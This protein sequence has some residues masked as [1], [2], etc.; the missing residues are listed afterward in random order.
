MRSWSCRLFVVGTILAAYASAAPVSRIV[1]DGDFADWQ[2]V[3]VHTDPQD[4]QHDT[5]HTLPSDTPAYVDHEDVDL[6][7][8]KVTHDE[9]NVYAYFKSRGIIGRTQSHTEGTAGRYYVIVTLDV[10]QNDT[11][12]YWL[13]EG[14]YYPT[15]SGYDMNMEV[16]FYDAAF[17]TGHYLNHGCLDETEYL[18]AQDDQSNGFIIVKAGTYDWY[19][20]W[21]WWD[22]PQGN[23]GEITL[24]DGH[25]TIMWVEDRGPVY[26]GIIEI[27]V[28]ADGHE[29]EMKAP[30]R[31]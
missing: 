9:D 7:E 28:S 26:Q 30:F 22:T 16:E 15:S 31:G 4:D 5:D 6:I 3:P 20:Q 18:Q 24:P 17:N 21:V 25:S 14:G 12:G 2:Y 13:N 10:D 11:T 19:T 1:L 29:A 23:L 8:F 27:A